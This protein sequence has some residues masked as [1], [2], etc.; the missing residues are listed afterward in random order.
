MARIP[1]ELIDRIRDS[2][3]I[4]DVISQDVQLR[5]QGK[6]LMGHCP[7]HRDD[8]P[9]FAVS[10]Q[11]QF[12]YC[13]S[14]HRSGNVF[15]FLQQ[16]HQ[17]SF[18]EAVARVAEMANI[19]LPSQY[20]PGKDKHADTQ[21]SE[22]G[23]LLNLHAASAKLYH[24]I[25]VSTEAGRA[26]MHYL[27]K[28][29]MSRQL[30]DEFNLGFAPVG[31][32]EVLLEY[33]QQQ[34]LD[35]QLLRKSGLFVTDRD[36]N[37]H[38][39]F[40]GRVMYPLDS[41]NG[42]VVGFSGRIL[43][44][45]GNDQEP[46][47][48]NSPETEIFNKRQNLFNLH[49]AKKAA[50]TA[51][52]LIL[53]EGFMDVISA[54]GAGVLNGVAS[55]GTSLTDD[56][57]QVIQRFSNKVVVCYDGDDAGQHAIDRAIK[58]IQQDG[59]QLKIR[60][61]QLPAGLD[62]DEYVQQKGAQSFQDYLQ[63]HEE[64]PVEFQIHYL[65]RGLNL[66]QQ[67]ELISY[68]NAVLQIIA[69]V[70]SPVEQNV[71][72]KELATEFGLSVDSLQDQVHQISK[73]LPKQPQRQSVSSSPAAALAPGEDSRVATRVMG[74]V[75]SAERRLLSYYLN[76]EEV[77][78]HLDSLNG[79]QFAHDSY[80]KVY[81]AVHAY[82]DG[83]DQVSIAALLDQL[84]DGQSRAVLSEVSNLKVDRDA[85]DEV[86]NDCIGV[87]M[88]EAPLKQQIQAKKAAL[89]EAAMVNDEEATTKIAQELVQLYQKQ[90]NMKTE[91][92][93]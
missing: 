84:P 17:L 23:Q 79:F 47:Y 5:A 89:N 82:L 64:T 73:A 70:S 63:G 87:I 27:Q 71:Y 85:T 52:S 15:G 3:N 19:Q 54:F 58:L 33:C 16:L 41:G 44:K 83:H 40:H 2:V 76:D 42:Q 1:N 62:P 36:G 65:R 86:V 43:A 22:V 55:M 13:F 32:E 9:S 51:G 56:Q 45:K 7:F 14:C 60:I 48:L 91:E 81:L 49:R 8:T 20:E 21:T 68:L 31:D 77:R 46:K 18:P 39:R 90:Q 29:G 12:F 26:A 78:S 59:P 6:N 24:H 4:V 75:E 74:K 66:H 37:L 67:D 10:E 11:K 88:K 53:F 93:G 28:R 25:L 34:K 80:Q 38:D 35:Y 92:I 30:I 50:R 69:G 57:V 61:V 72:L